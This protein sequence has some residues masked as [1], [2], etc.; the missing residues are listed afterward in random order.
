[1]L[2]KMKQ[3][4]NGDI[5]LSRKLGDDIK[6]QAHVRLSYSNLNN[7]LQIFTGKLITFKIGLKQKQ[8]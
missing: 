6:G 5:I 7:L 2:V 8:D 3:F 1:M 4:S